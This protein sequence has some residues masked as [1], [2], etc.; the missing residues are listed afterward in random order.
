MM[1]DAKAPEAIVK[2][3]VKGAK[4]ACESNLQP[5]GLLALVRN[6]GERVVQT[7]RNRCILDGVDVLPREI[8]VGPQKGMRWTGLS[9]TV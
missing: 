3:L 5:Q 8:G 1:E 2:S 4:L 9:P 6:V 7:E